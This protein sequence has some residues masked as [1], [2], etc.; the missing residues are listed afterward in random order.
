[1]YGLTLCLPR[2]GEPQGLPVSREI[3]KNHQE[4]V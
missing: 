2:V 1:M 3:P 4:G